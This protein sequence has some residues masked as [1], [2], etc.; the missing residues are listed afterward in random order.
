MQYRAN[1]Q[2]RVEFS[3]QNLPALV[4]LESLLERGD[5]E[6]AGCQRGRAHPNHSVGEGAEVTHARL[7]RR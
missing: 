5:A 2:V 1:E 3:D 6:V 7:V 4:K